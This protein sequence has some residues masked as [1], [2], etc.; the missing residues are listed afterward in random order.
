MKTRDFGQKDPISALQTLL[1]TALTVQARQ[2]RRAQ[3]KQ[4]AGRPLEELTEQ[5][6]NVTRSTT[7]LIAECRKGGKDMRDAGKAMTMDERVQT[8]VA[9]LADLPPARRNEVLERLAGVGGAEVAT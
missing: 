2:I 9:F 6:G 3:G 5:L 1:L 4:M 8:V 7:A